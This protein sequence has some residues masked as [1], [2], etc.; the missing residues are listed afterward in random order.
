M[1]PVT[2]TGKAPRWFY[3]RK[4]G[5]GIKETP[6]TCLLSSHFWVLLASQEA[7]MVRNLPANAGDMRYGFDIWVGKIP[8]RRKWQPIPVFLSGES[9]GQRSLAGYSPWGCKRS[10]MTV[11][12]NNR[13]QKGNTLYINVN[14]W[15]LKLRAGRWGVILYP[16]R[17]VRRLRTRHVLPPLPRNIV[18]PIGLCEALLWTV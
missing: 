5:F 10:N 6:W 2:G 12:L 4:E 18:R 15:I 9:H 17:K 7:L 16:A 3:W 1:W 14:T 8:W 11:R 13:Q